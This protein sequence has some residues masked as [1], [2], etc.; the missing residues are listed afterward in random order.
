MAQGVEGFRRR[1]RG[2]RLPAAVR[3]LGHGRA[4][5][6]RQQPAEARLEPC[7]VRSR[8]NRRLPD[9]VPQPQMAAERRDRQRRVTPT[10]TGRIQSSAAQNGQVSALYP[11]RTAIKITMAGS[12]V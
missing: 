3:H 11:L 6:Q 10:Q 9:V 7:G 2:R 1:R 4:Q 8:E 12:M 5:Q